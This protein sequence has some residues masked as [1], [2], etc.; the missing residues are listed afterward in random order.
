MKIVIAMDS[1]KGSVSSLRAGQAVADGVLRA[2]PEAEICIL[3]LADGGEGTAELICTA[4]GGE[5][6]EKTVTGPLGTP[7]SARWQFL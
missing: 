2:A 7:V 1:F 5:I 3:G 6:L 4:M